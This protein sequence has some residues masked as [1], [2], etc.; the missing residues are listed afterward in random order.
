MM[1]AQK[2]A[3]AF[4]SKGALERVF[5]SEIA[6]VLTPVKA[7]QPLTSCQCQ[8]L[9]F[10]LLKETFPCFWSHKPRTFPHPAHRPIELSHTVAALLG[11]TAH[12]LPF[13]LRLEGHVVAVPAATRTHLSTM[14]P[15]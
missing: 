13:P 11:S 7:L 8:M 2:P 10:W 14:S 5:T 6:Q 1:L 4:H 15:A 9:S 12:L 3:V